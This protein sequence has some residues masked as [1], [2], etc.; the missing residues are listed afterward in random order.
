MG[1]FSELTSM[2]DFIA[3]VERKNSIANLANLVTLLIKLLIE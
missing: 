3:F 1:G 2:R